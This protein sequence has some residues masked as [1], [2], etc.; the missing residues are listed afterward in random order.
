VGGGREVLEAGGAPRRSLEGHAGPLQVWDVGT[1]CP[2][3]PRPVPTSVPG[4][5]LLGA[6][7]EVAGQTNTEQARRT[8]PLPSVAAHRPCPHARSRT[9][10]TTRS[11]CGSRR[12]PSTRPSGMIDRVVGGATR[13][14]R[15][16]HREARWDSSA[17][18]SGIG[19]THGC[20]RWHT[21]RALGRVPRPG[22]PRA[23]ILRA[24]ATSPGNSAAADA[25]QT[26][27][28]STG[29]D[30]S[31]RA[32]PPVA[33]VQPRVT[34]P[35]G[36][37]GSRDAGPGGPVTWDPTRG[38]IGPEPPNGDRGGRG[39]SAAWDERHGTPEPT[40]EGRA[41]LDLVRSPPVGAT[42][43]APRS[44]PHRRTS[45]R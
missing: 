6:V 28:A 3:E 15:P 35:C 33:G 40:G 39:V 12:G 27:A 4:I 24:S 21:S 13:R 14:G 7:V 16:P 45:S 19:T 32:S 2:G 37:R 1:P 25:V 26:P 29:R 9:C 23:P 5:G 38:T 43:R 36:G 34:A 18:G 31:G 42:R 30:R 41:I 17:A 10:G 11:R 44:W 20:H 22:R 8:G